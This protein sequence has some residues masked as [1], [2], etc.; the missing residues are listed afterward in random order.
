[1]AVVALAA[2]MTGIRIR[3]RSPEGY[4]PDADDLA[5]VARLGGESR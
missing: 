2:A 4:E 1:V 5:R 3:N